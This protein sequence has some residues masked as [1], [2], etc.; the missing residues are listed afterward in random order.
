MPG[1]VSFGGLQGTLG[2]FVCPA[3]PSAFLLSSFLCCYRLL[4]SEKGQKGDWCISAGL[5]TSK[6]VS[7]IDIRVSFGREHSLGRLLLG[8]CFSLV[9]DDVGGRA[10]SLLVLSCH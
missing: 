5:A 9:D 10:G 4:V 3:F 6:A 2:L 7:S 8:L 1:L